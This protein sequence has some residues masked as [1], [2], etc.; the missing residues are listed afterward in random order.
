MRSGYHL[1]P[2]LLMLAAAANAAADTPASECVSRLGPDERLVHDAASAKLRVG[3]A[4]KSALRAAAIALVREGRLSIRA[5]PKAAR[6]AARC[7]APAA[8]E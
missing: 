1:L 7:L 3:A 2:P 5:A 4:P 8:S 6:A